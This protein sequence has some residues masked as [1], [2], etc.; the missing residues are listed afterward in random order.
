MTAFWKK[1]FRNISELSKTLG[2]NYAQA[3][4]E[5][6]FYIEEVSSRIFYVLWQLCPLMGPTSGIAACIAFVGVDR[7][8]N[9][10]YKTG[11]HFVV[12]F[13]TGLAYKCDSKIWQMP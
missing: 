4:F 11:K 10:L 7:H 1:A 8:I 6:L 5:S 13:N 3:Y 2:R 12:D 9:S